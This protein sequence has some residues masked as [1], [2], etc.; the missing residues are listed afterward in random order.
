M[1]G[2]GPWPANLTQVHRLPRQATSRQL[3]ETGAALRALTREALLSS[4]GPGPG[5]PSGMGGVGSVD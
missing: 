1:A 2:E 5:A 3:C 4:P